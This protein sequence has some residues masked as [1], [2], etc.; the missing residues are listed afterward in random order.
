MSKNLYTIRIKGSI[1]HKTEF[2]CER[3]SW[4]NLIW[5]LFSGYEKNDLEILE[6]LSSLVYMSYKAMTQKEG[7]L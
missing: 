2:R 5:Y 4:R 6:N 7:N 3:F 1:S